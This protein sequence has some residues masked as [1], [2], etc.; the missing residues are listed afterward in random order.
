MAIVGIKIWLD[1]GDG[2]SHP[3]PAA[4]SADTPAFGWE[5]P[6]GAFQAAYILELRAEGSGL[7]YSSGRVASA[8]PAHRV[9]ESLPLATWAGLVEVRLRL[10][11]V[12]GE[13]VA[14]THYYADSSPT[15]HSDA[16]GLYY[17]RVA[18]IPAIAGTITPRLA[19]RLATDPDGDAL[20]YQLQWAAT[21]LFEAGA[22]YAAGTAG[23]GELEVAASDGVS[24][25][26]EPT[27]LLSGWVFWRVRA[28]D[29]QDYGPWAETAVFRFTPAAAPVA[30]F[31]WVRTD[32]TAA[33]SNAAARPAGEVQIA[34]RV[35]DSDSAN[36]SAWL[37]ASI[38][39]AAPVPLALDAPLLSIPAGREIVAVWL[40]ERQIPDSA[41]TVRLFLN[42]ADGANAAPEVEYDSVVY[43]NNRGIGADGTVAASDNRCGIAGLC[44][45]VDRFIL[46]PAEHVKGTGDAASPIGP[47]PAGED[48]E[49]AIGVDWAAYWAAILGEYYARHKWVGGLLLCQRLPAL[50]KRPNYRY[51]DGYDDGDCR[52]DAELL[53]LSYRDEFEARPDKFHEKWAECIPGTGLG[54]GLAGMLYF[55]KP[56][57]YGRFATIRRPAILYAG[58]SGVYYDG[59]MLESDP[60]KLFRAASGEDA[61]LPA[62]ARELLDSDFWA[63]FPA[64]SPLHSPK[65]PKGNQL[66][67]RW[68]GPAE[69]AETALDADGWYW[70]RFEYPIKIAAPTVV[71]RG[72]NDYFAYRLNGGDIVRGSILPDGADTGFIPLQASA[73][74]SLLEMLARLFPPEIF[75]SIAAEDIEG[76]SYG[77]RLTARSRRRETLR[78]FR[79]VGAED[80]AGKIFGL[81]GNIRVALRHPA[82]G[83]DPEYG[84]AYYAEYGGEG[85]DDMEY[86]CG[87]D[88]GEWIGSEGE[89]N[90][91]EPLFTCDPD[92]VNR[93]GCHYKYTPRRFALSGRVY[94]RKYRVAMAYPS[95]DPAPLRAPL[96]GESEA[97]AKGY[98]AFTLAYAGKNALGEELFRRIPA[99]GMG[100]LP[101]VARRIPVR[102]G[103]RDFEEDGWWLAD[104]APAF[105]P[106]D[107]VSHRFDEAAGRYY[108]LPPSGFQERLA[109]IPILCA[110]YVDIAEAWE[111]PALGLSQ[112]AGR[113]DRLQPVANRGAVSYAWF[114][115]VLGAY[116]A[117]A[118]LPGT[119]ESGYEDYAESARFK[120]IWGDDSSGEEI[121]G[122]TIDPGDIIP[123]ARVGLVGKYGYQPDHTLEEYFKVSEM[124][125]GRSITF[126]GAYV[127]G[128]TTDVGLSHRLPGFIHLERLLL[129]DTSRLE[130][131]P[132]QGTKAPFMDYRVRGRLS[133]AQ[134]AYFSALPPEENR[135]YAR[136][137]VGPYAEDR[138]LRIS[139]Y[140][141]A[142]SRDIPLRII[143]LQT[144]W[145]TYNLIHWEG[146]QDSGVAALLEAAPVDSAGAPGEWRS[147]R[148]T[149]AEWN[150][151]AGAW[152][153]PYVRLR[154]SAYLD[155]L[156]G[157]LYPRG[158]GA[159]SAFV[160]GQRYIFRLSAV[161]IHSGAVSTPW[162][163][164][165]FTYSREAWSPPVITG[166]EYD[167]WR[168]E[169]VLTFRFDDALGRRY[170]I[171]NLHY[172]SYI[173]EDGNPADDA[174]VELGTAVL[175]GDLEDLASNRTGEIYGAGMTAIVHR[176]RLAASLLGD[177]DGRLVRFRLTGVPS[178]A[179]AGMD[180]PVF[181]F[182]M[183]GNERLKAAEDAIVSA[184]GRTCRWVLEETVDAETGA[185]TTRWKYVDR[186][187]AVTIPGEITIQATAIARVSTEFEEWYATAAK[188]DCPDYDAR[189]A[190]LTGVG[191]TAAN[192]AL[193]AHL[194]TLRAGFIARFHAAAYAE[195]E[196][197]YR[198]EDGTQPRRAAWL[199][200]RFVDLRG[201]AGDF[202]YW[203]A[204]K[205]PLLLGLPDGFDA[206]RAVTA[207]KDDAT[208]RADY[209]AANYADAYAAWLSESGR[210]DDDASRQAY[211]AAND[212]L[213]AWAAYAT[214]A[215][216]YHDGRYAARKAYAESHAAEYAAWIAA[217][218]D[219]FGDAINLP[220]E[221]GDRL[222]LFAAANR[223]RWVSLEAEN[224][225]RQAAWDAFLSFT[226]SGI[227]YGQRLAGA[228]AARDAANARLLAAYRRKAELE[229]AFRAE[230]IGKGYFCNGWRGNSPVRA[231]GSENLVFRFRVENQP[232]NGR[233]AATYTPAAGYDYGDVAAPLAGWDDRWNIYFRFQLDFYDSFDSQDGKPLRDY[234]WQRLDCSGY[235]ADATSLDVR[236]GADGRE[237]IRI[238]GGIEADSGGMHI[239]PGDVYNPNATG[240][241]SPS[242]SDPYSFQFAG[243][244]AIPKYELPGE[245]ETDALPAGWGSGTPKAGAFNHV[246]FW[247]VRPYNLVERPAMEAIFAAFGEPTEIGPGEYGERLWRVAVATA[248]FGGD[249]HVLLGS[250]E[251][252]G[253]FAAGPHV[254]L[255][256]AV[257]RRDAPIAYLSVT[258]FDGATVE[259]AGDY[260]LLAGTADSPAAV[261]KHATENWYIRRNAASQYAEWAVYSTSGGAVPEP[262]P[263]YE[264]TVSGAPIAA[265]NGGYNPL[266]GVTG[267]QGTTVYANGN[268]Y[269][270]AYMNDDNTGG[271]FWV[272][273]TFYAY[274]GNEELGDYGELDQHTGNPDAVFAGRWE[275]GT[276]VE[277]AGGSGSGSGDYDYLALIY[278]NHDANPLAGADA[279]FAGGYDCN[280]YTTRYHGAPIW[281][282][283][284]DGECWD[285]VEAAYDRFFPATSDDGFDLPLAQNPARAAHRLRMARGELAFMTDRPRMLAEGG[286]VP[287]PDTE[288]HFAVDWTGVGRE[289]AKPWAWRD[290]A[291]KCWRM[292]C[293]K[294][295][296]SVDGRTD[297]GLVL[298]LGLHPNCWAEERLI[299]PANPLDFPEDAAGFPKDALAGAQSF[300]SPCVVK[301]SGG[302]WL[303][304]ALRKESGREIWRAYSKDLAAW[305]GFRKCAFAD[306]NAPADPAVYA[307]EDGY[308]LYGV[309]GTAIRC[310]AS[311]DGLSFASP[312][313]IYADWYA[314]SRPSVCGGRLY[315]GMESGAYGKIYSIPLAGGALKAEKGNAPSPDASPAPG[316]GE[317]WFDPF[318][319]ADC[320]R[321]CPI[322]RLLYR[323]S[324]EAYIF[325]DDPE[326]PAA[327]SGIMEDCL[328]TEYLEEYEW[329]E[330]RLVDEMGYGYAQNTRRLADG[331]AV[332][333]IADAAGNA[334]DLEAFYAEMPTGSANIVFACDDE[335]L[336]FRLPA[337]PLAETQIIEAEGEWLD[338][339]NVGATAA[340]LRPEEAPDG[341][342]AASYDCA[343]YIAR[344]G[345]VAEYAEWREAT[346]VDDTA[347]ARAEFL[348]QTGKY[349]AY[350]EW[351]KR[352]PCI[353]RYRH[354][355]R[356]TAYWGD[357]D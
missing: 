235:A 278:I 4:S 310:Y 321:G 51:Y 36:V 149:T 158:G 285:P 69:N 5:I 194:D 9:S 206:W 298:C 70:T 37:S 201:L 122:T 38:G 351:A 76:T 225:G 48:A 146:T 2:I 212:L 250:A 281:R 61:E 330:I 308:I 115:H 35:D 3:L 192:A 340:I 283:D 202:A 19:W 59:A 247:R 78:L 251:G 114:R 269:Y 168:H 94:I 124:W 55:L 147:V 139:G 169:F 272:L 87:C 293:Q 273:S 66:R 23:I 220:A 14:T 341:Y 107:C 329:R 167:S 230:L 246:Y 257:A 58:E 295:L 166:V 307:T 314:L 43:V 223:E 216:R 52:V 21:P 191:T 178:E 353:F 327:A 83:F 72:E 101:P 301:V 45:D 219:G 236:I 280:G 12:M 263:E 155:T 126:P 326:E 312:A 95:E 106:K 316:A 324:A 208:T 258:G 176:V 113:I 232:A 89:I 165:P 248:F 47:P 29:G 74:A 296:R 297:C 319:F 262:A 228:Y 347:A 152:V 93:N 44:R 16:D 309:V 352:G 128:I 241:E 34:V 200:E 7:L 173:E 20:T 86:E 338:S 287:I 25:A 49:E 292:V 179:R 286:L 84:L 323:H 209:I 238:P 306:G 91:A 320:D 313:V 40:S 111:K 121:A 104:S 117:G 227:S 100:G 15:W 103:G 105:A 242:S 282:R 284:P 182:L 349:P 300:E 125:E 163:S 243:K 229:C 332:P 274:T 56:A 190:F 131:P 328:F 140:I 325:A 245:L 217:P 90:A 343:A 80:G 50:V 215:N 277:A 207:V 233:V 205:G 97:P 304:F 92:F 160:D 252:R 317:A 357:G 198:A 99:P 291:A 33:D 175:T 54:F 81:D 118:A 249:A 344:M 127:H 134:Y 62:G 224:P 210:A 253:Q 226:V 75:D 108:R 172:A 265:A 85:G 145:N 27:I 102:F 322:A 64:L 133:Y 318:V 254:R 204:N 154:Q 17:L 189:R 333:I 57:A 260:Y 355:V 276:I 39:G 10:Y 187:E 136:R 315:F 256:V 196:T 195:F 289:R 32:C 186:A 141:D 148:T 213:S 244:F 221:D 79:F 346:A 185:V 8:T 116:R 157:R 240:D 18:S 65:P 345:L 290:D 30:R 255:H 336:A 110:E 137:P 120:E 275:R 211:L 60:E 41:A 267:Y 151:A 354:A 270:L 67:R 305:D 98:R 177:L 46:A 31:C 82:T 132:E 335:P 203:T 130:L 88:E 266:A 156:N 299:L 150:A 288:G 24:V 303:Y 231:G 302:Y 170:D 162:Q 279:L 342:D 164:A 42:A 13:L 259:Y 237:Y 119:P 123:V 174:F 129:P 218:A 234:L 138:P 181:E 199:R 214:L 109:P 77:Y 311:S 144:E 22:A 135:A 356:G 264:Y 188:W 271:N 184:A 6:A 112:G 143:Y 161:N 171:T 71:R 53:D 239:L 26:A 11:N 222:M 159:A 350:L 334:V 348:L 183:W 63:T 197:G 68:L 331:T 337:A 268:G 28:Y 1:E 339:A 180:T 294:P 261:W 96:P 153:V 73:P 142:L 193:A